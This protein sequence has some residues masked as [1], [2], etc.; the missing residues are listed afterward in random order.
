MKDPLLL[1]G[2]ILLVILL[3]WKLF[4][5][6]MKWG[7]EIYLPPEGAD[8]QLKKMLEEAK[9]SHKHKEIASKM[10]KLISDIPDENQKILYLCKLGEL[11]KG[12]LKNKSKA[13][14]YYTKAMEYD[15]FCKTAREEIKSLLFNNKGAKRAERIY[16]I[17]LSKIEP[18]N[19]SYKDIALLLTDL[20][21]LYSNML[22]QP[23]RGEAIKN[24]SEYIKHSKQEIVEKENS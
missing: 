1:I 23:R 6:G 8:E 20:S 9:T 22:K 5:K 3:I 21:D 14:K 10:E 13:V 15:P 12:P 17:V 18:Q 2:V 11:N 16:W 4:K 24:I 7:D 19:D